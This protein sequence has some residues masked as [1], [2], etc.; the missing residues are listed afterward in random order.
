MASIVRPMPLSLPEC[1][2]LS[3]AA[4]CDATVS[5]YGETA[6]V[7]GNV[8]KQYCVTGTFTYPVGAAPPPL[9]A[10]LGGM[11]TY[12]PFKA[13][14]TDGTF[15]ATLT[16]K[17][18]DDFIYGC[19]PLYTASRYW[20]VTETG[21]LKATIS[22]TYRDEDINGPEGSYVVLRNEGTTTGVPTNSGVDTATNTATAVDVENFS[23][24]AAGNLSVTA[25]SA[26]ISGRIL[27]AEGQGI[28]NA[29][30]IL[31]GGSLAQPILVRTGTFGY[32]EFTGIP[33]GATYFVTVRSKRYQFAN[34]TRV[35]T[36]IDD[37]T[38]LD[39]TAEPGSSGLQSET[40]PLKKE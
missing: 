6:F 37:V 7:I 18:V 31:S 30:A 28:R 3:A 5:G 39:F 34:P 2:S 36:T 23:K 22:F 10:Q 32:F 26:R 1:A 25:S 14:V 35:V 8:A 38:G 27:T 12:S 17:A 16:V 20:D 29:T 24:W 33:S 9:T 15:P 13:V 21:T 11:G 4:G 19:N 40:I